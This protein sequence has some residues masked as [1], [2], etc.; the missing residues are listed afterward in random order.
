LSLDLIL[1]LSIDLRLFPILILDSK[2]CLLPKKGLFTL[3]YLILI[4]VFVAFKCLNP[5]LKPAIFNILYSGL[6][7]SK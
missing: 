3:A 6:N 1:T 4:L 2:L 7:R 5:K